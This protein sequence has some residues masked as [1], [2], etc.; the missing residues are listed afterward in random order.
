MNA[1]PADSTD[2]EEIRREQ[3]EL[4]GLFM[5]LL[6]DLNICE[7]DMEQPGAVTYRDR[8]YARALFALIEGV[9]YRMRRVLI[10]GAKQGRFAI[11]SSDLRKLK[12]TR[13]DTAAN[14]NDP[15]GRARFLPIREGLKV[16]LRLWADCFGQKLPNNCF[17]GDAWAAVLRAVEARHA[18]TH[19]KFAHDLVITNA[20]LKDLKTTKSWMMHTMAHLLQVLPT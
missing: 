14:G 3:S 12:E 7:E 2:V 8:A 11:S 18:V 10:A 1:R 13:S 15:P 6:G 17:S 9:T 5:M 16:T 4:A 19:P 20:R